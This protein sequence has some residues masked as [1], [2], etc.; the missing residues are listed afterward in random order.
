[1]KMLQNIVSATLLSLLPTVSL[2]ADSCPCCPDDGP[3]PWCPLP[4]ICLGDEDEGEKTLR[5]IDEKDPDE[6]A[7]RPLIARP[8]LALGDDEKDGD[9]CCSLEDNEREDGDKDSARLC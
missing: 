5:G 3:C 9:K 2:L 6:D 8:F 7:D 1:M 4:G